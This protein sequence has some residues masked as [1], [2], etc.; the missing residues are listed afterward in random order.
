[1]VP[2]FY[3]MS[4]SLDL[5]IMHTANSYP[6][7]VNLANIL[8]KAVILFNLASFP[9]VG[10]H[11][12]SLHRV[13]VPTTKNLKVVSYADPSQW[14]KPSFAPHPTFFLVELDHQVLLLLSCLQALPVW[15]WIW[16]KGWLGLAW[17]A[18]SLPDQEESH[19]QLNHLHFKRQLAPFSLL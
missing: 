12:R 15:E 2:N 13:N 4:V 6:Q 16:R 9:L 19:K 7:N 8:Q 5:F 17:L 11:P 3:C 1:M 10:P 18:K 14:L